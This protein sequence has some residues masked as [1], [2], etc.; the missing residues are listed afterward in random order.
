LF[1]LTISQV[2]NGI[3]ALLFFLPEREVLFQELNDAL[4]VAEF[5]LFELVNP[6]ES[7]LES[8]V[9]Q[10]ACLAVILHHLVVE[11]REVQSE[12][13]LDGVAGGQIN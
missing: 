2:I 7:G 13:K 4:G 9:S 12:S 6:F 1:G 3:I 11:H 10:L 8:I 5:V